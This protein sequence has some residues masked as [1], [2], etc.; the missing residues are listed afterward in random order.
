MD[1]K[2]C[3]T[4]IF[5]GN[6]RIS[7]FCYFVFIARFACHFQYCRVFYVFQPYHLFLNVMMVFLVIACT[8]EKLGWGNGICG[9]FVSGGVG[10]NQNFSCLIRGNLLG[11]LAAISYN[12]FS[13]LKHYETYN[14][15]GLSDVCR[16]SNPRLL[17]R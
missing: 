10:P 4:I 1:Y 17:C 3:S 11:V 7:L 16:H 15:A 5:N 12:S 13:I 6:I 9:A 14:L 8:S 2:P